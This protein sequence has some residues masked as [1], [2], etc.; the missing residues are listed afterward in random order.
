M[1]LSHA[2]ADARRVGASL[3]LPTLSLDEGYAVAREVWTLLG[4][5]VGW[6]VGATNANGQRFL[7]IDAPIRGRVFRVVEAG[8]A[9]LAIGPDLAPGE[10]PLEAE[11]EIIFIE[12]EPDPRIGIEIVRPSSATPFDDGVGAIIADNAAHVVLV[13]GA[14]FDAALLDTPER[15][16]VALSRNDAVVA[17]G[18][19]AAVLGDPRR[20]RDWLAGEET[21]APGE[22]IAS[23]A[24]TRAA[25]FAGGDTIVADFGPLGRIVLTRP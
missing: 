17:E 11:P 5:P 18:D 7:G 23:G 6:K 10:R 2:I 22:W 19:A 14:A 1:S 15:V 13:V 24:M 9:P 16:T 3:A 8:V 4:P 21:L 25:P 20:A 12:G